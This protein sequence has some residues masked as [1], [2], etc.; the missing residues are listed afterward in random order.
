M[1]LKPEI[2]AEASG[3]ATREP[4][5]VLTM[6]E[7][8]ADM[9]AAEKAPR[10]GAIDKLG[11]MVAGA[12]RA[13]PGGIWLA[14]KGTAALLGAPEKEIAQETERALKDNP[15][16]A[17]AGTVAGA[18]GTGGALT[19][20]A[21]MGLAKGA[22][23]AAG[24]AALLAPTYKLGEIAN[25]AQLSGD[26]LQIEH[27]ANA[28]DWHDIATAGGLAAVLHVPLM[29][30][31]TALGAGA[32]LASTAAKS[33]GGAFSKAAQKLG[34][35]EEQAGRIALDAD[36]MSKSG[37]TAK[38]LAETGKVIGQAENAAQVDSVFRDV[39]ASKL[40]GVAQEAATPGAG[41]NSEVKDLQIR[42][43][44]VRDSDIDGEG[45]GKLISSLNEKAVKSKER[46]VRE[47]YFTAAK[48]MRDSLADHLD[49]VDPQVGSQYRAAVHDYKTYSRMSA[50]AERAVDSQLTGR[51]IAG[52][53]GQTAATAVLGK[54]IG[55][56]PAGLVADAVVGGASARQLLRKNPAIL[57]DRLAK[58]APTEL[59]EG[60][61]AQALKDLASPSPASAA[62]AV[63]NQSKADIDQQYLET[64]RALRHSLQ[65]PS[66]TSVKLRGQLNFLPPLQADAVTAN[67]M[68]K[69]RVSAM[70]I[71]TSAGPQTLF[72]QQ[73][74]VS[75]REK[76]EYLR[77]V[78]ATFNPLEAIKS[79]RADLV[80]HAEKTNPETIHELRKRVIEQFTSG[81]PVDYQTKRR[82]SG[83]LGAAGTPTQNSALGATLQNIITARKHAQ[84]DSGQM[85]S[86]RQAKAQRKNDLAT[87]S[88]GQSLVHNLD[89][90]K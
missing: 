4:G 2:L 44:E 13:I 46:S 34:I 77:R 71:P 89:G 16:Y 24:Q 27:I 21:G 11:S 67:T 37:A 10:E 26:A 72:G 40:E 42:A 60:R 51:D 29:G 33:A 1:P 85:H 39:L 48:Q 83:I 58:R 81:E 84:D 20:T 45:I 66:G 30:V 28:F 65:D 74:D 9:D 88:R 31:E 14:N 78:Q 25:Q 43:T 6:D 49:V 69:I 50:E 3:P 22:A 87:L 41:L 56:G 15:G 19:S 82:V 55:A 61:A 32:G 62:L 75:D 68:N 63:E 59:F 80:K 70:D 64:T 38:R 23:V 57:L 79:G 73:T 17:M 12:V 76:R 47:F 18:L 53:I 54:V 36:L 35:T 5:H 52:A 90:G 7:A 8:I 86:A